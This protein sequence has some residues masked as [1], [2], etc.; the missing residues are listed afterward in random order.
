MENMSMENSRRE[1]ETILNK[2]YQGRT[3]SKGEITFLLGLNDESQIGSLFQ[4][5]RDLRRIHFGDKVFLYG[6][7]YISTYCR[8]DCN[9]C[10][11][12]R[13]N[14]A[15]RR[16]RKEAPEIVDAACRLATSGVHLID[17]TMGEDLQ[18]FDSGAIGFEK[19]VELVTSVKEATGL[20]IMVSPGVVPDSILSKLAEAGATWY[21]CYQETHQRALF[22]QLRPGQSYDARMDNKRLAHSLGL[23][24]EE[25]V[26]SGVGESFDDVAES[27][28]V[29]Q[30]LGADQ[31]RVMSFVPQE[32][33]PMENWRSPDPK[34]ELKIIAVMRLVFPDRLIPASLDVGGLAGLKQRLDA[35]AN[36][37]TSLVP[38]GLGLAGVAQSSLDIKDARRTSASVLPVLE[39]CGLS[40]GSTQEYVSWIEGRWEKAGRKYSKQ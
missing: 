23:L 2:A 15:C 9:F 32:G 37:V 33:T 29:M 28:S 5:A 4:T 17:L 16:Y 26:L 3:L 31:V 20:P 1:L 34:R 10:F 14:T 21:A 36:V 18:Y 13:S 24:I 38:P 25:G 11:F 19:L 6:F 30:S 35:G 7:L 27:I 22:N 8:N 39:A 12:R 40:A